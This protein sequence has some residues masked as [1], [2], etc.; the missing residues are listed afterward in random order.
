MIVEH[1]E[2]ICACNSIAGPFDRIPGVGLFIGNLNDM[3]GSLRNETPDIQELY[4]EK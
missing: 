2:I 1:N 4:K 3:R